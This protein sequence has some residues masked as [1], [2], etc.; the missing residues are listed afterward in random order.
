M[1]SAKRIMLTGA[2]GQ[3]GQALRNGPLPAGWE[4]GAYS[5][6]EFD[7][8]D[9][10][11]VQAAMRDF[12]PDFIVN[13]AAMTA[14]DKAEGDLH[15]ATIVNFEALANLAAQCSA[16]DIPLLH[17]S[18][19]YVFDGQDNEVPYKT[20]DKMNPVNVY[21]HSKMMGEEALRHELAWHIILRVSSVFSSFSRNILT[22]FLK[23]IDERDEL[24]IITDQKSCPTYAPDIA[25]AII[26]MAKAV[27]AGK[28]DG[29]GTFHYCGEPAVTRFELFGEIM[30]A[31]APYTERHPSVVPV[32][33]ADLPGFA[34]RP[35]YSVLDCSKIRDVYGI[36]QR[37]W[38]D[39]LRDAMTILMR[40]RRKLS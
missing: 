14:V 11:A 34:P 7:I 25:K 30:K 28:H 22:N 5:R 38:R 19:D 2:N 4:L 16:M 29:F 6:A 32:K 10:G 18:T 36:A 37:P 13:A 26:E 1:S 3:I 9:H 24:K 20:D 21:G 17:L 8:T 40:E 15:Q 31:Y 12:K 35:A 33:S 23:M 39:G 27:C